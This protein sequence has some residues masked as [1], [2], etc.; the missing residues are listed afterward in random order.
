MKQVFV[1]WVSHIKGEMPGFHDGV[2]EMEE[3]PKSKSDIDQLR[4]MLADKNF[5]GGYPIILSFQEL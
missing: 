5:G 1:S 2:F 4:I 3:V